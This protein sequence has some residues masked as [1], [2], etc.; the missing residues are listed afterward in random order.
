M[1]HR[2]Q[3]RMNRG[4]AG[5]PAQHCERPASIKSDGSWLCAEHYDFLMKVAEQHRALDK[6]YDES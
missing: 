2:C 1:S 4:T 3:F 6:Y 5:A